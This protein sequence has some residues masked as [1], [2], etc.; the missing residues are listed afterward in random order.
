MIEFL[1]TEGFQVRR[2]LGRE[3]QNLTYG[4]ISIRRILDE[5]F[6]ITLDREALEWPRAFLGSLTGLQRSLLIPTLQVCLCLDP[7]PLLVRTEDTKSHKST[8]QKGRNGMQT[9]TVDSGRHQEN[10][11]SENLFSPCIFL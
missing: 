2:L 3:H 5:V 9:L 6:P 10:Q 4:Y 11:Q 7:L 8:S 1:R